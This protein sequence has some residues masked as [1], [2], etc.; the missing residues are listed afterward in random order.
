MRGRRRIVNGD[1]A[2]GTRDTECIDLPPI[3]YVDD[4]ARYLGRTPKAVRTAVARGRLP[5]PLRLAGRLAWRA[6]DVL[7]FVSET[8]AASQTSAKPVN[9][10]AERYHYDKSRFR[11][12]FALPKLPGQPRQRV[13]K[14][15]PAGLDR[16]QA[17]AWG[18]KL[19]REVLAEL[20]RGTGREEVAPQ[21]LPLPRALRSKPAGDPIPTLSEFWVRLTNEYLAHCKPA[22]RRAYNS[23]WANYL[24]PILGAYR[25]DEINRAALAKL[26]E[27]INKLPEISSRNQILYKLRKIYERAVAWY[28]IDEEHVPLIK[29]DKEGKKPDPIVYTE[30]QAAR[31]IAAARDMGDDYLAIVLLM[32]HGALRVCEVAALRW[33]DVNLAAGVMTIKH[34][35]SDGEDATP[36]GGEALPVGLTPDLAGILAALPREGEHV[37]YRE[38]QGRARGKHKAQ[39]THHSEHSLTYRL[40]QVQARA[41]LPETGPHLLRHSGLTILARRGCDPWR[42]QAHARHARLATTQKYVHL[43]REASAREAAAFWNPPSPA[44]PKTPRGAKSQTSPKRPKRPENTART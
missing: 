13:H 32:L 43:A 44:V 26:K 39:R 12:T 35:Y 17:L 31:L 40:N 2:A 7:D 21:P 27:K 19:E 6:R 42:L 34:N 24:G 14:V 30:E 5:P 25:L 41:G 15:A 23:I 37:L 20:L 22:T 11:V 1:G 8:H 9:I 18:K 3:L 16:E 28:V 38:V 10:T 4:L 33:A 29:T 36:K